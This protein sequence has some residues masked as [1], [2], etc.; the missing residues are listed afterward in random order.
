MVHFCCLFLHRPAISLTLVANLKTYLRHDVVS[1]NNNYLRMYEVVIKYLWPSRYKLLI[2][3]LNSTN[4]ESE[5]N[6]NYNLMITCTLYRLV[7]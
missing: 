3:L 5:A 6:P 2:F 7:Y 4:T 1:Y